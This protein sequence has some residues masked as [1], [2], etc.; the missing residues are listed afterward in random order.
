MSKQIF[1][2]IEDLAT[3]GKVKEGFRKL[4]IKLPEDEALKWFKAF[5]GREPGDDYSFLE[6]GEAPDMSD[7]DIIVYNP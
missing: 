3:G 2:Y 4:Y 1:T 7:G 5:F 6:A